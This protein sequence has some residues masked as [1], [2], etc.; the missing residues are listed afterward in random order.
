MAPSA[1]DDRSQAKTTSNAAKTGSNVLTLCN[2]I[3]GKVS[4]ATFVDKTTTAFYFALNHP[5][6]LSAA[7]AAAQ[8]HEPMTDPNQDMVDRVEQVLGHRFKDRDLLQRALTHASVADDRLQSNERLEFLGDAVLGFV[9]C[10][11]LFHRFP[12]RQEGEL[13]KLKSAV[14]SRRVCAE[15]AE[16]IGLIDLLELGK[17]MT[18]RH[19]LP[20]SIAAAVYESVV[21]A[22]YIEF[23]L[24]AARKFI[25]DHMDPAITQADE[26]EHQHN[27]KS[28]LQQ[29]AQRL[30]MDLPTYRVLD[31]KG[32]DHSKCF[33]VGVTMGGRAFD[34]A[35]G[36][37]KKEAEQRAAYH[38]LEALGVIDD[39]SAEDREQESEDT[40]Q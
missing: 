31:E 29:H 26:S 27:Y 4:I 32:P 9:V 2:I 16:Q 3:I 28:A 10:E 12:D 23:G 34:P 14:V 15:V 18:A 19:Q 39:V 6:C 21:G 13:T 35:W 38:A 7:S 5:L 33:E 20:A 22:L 24:D 11:R 1:Q 25:L 36:T 8:S 17:G 37:S 40:G 30:G